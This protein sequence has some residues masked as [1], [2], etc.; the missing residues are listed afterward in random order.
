[1][2]FSNELIKIFPV[3]CFHIQQS[4]L[5]NIFMFVFTASRR[6][7]YIILIEMDS[8]YTG[9]DVYLHNQLLLLKQNDCVLELPKIIL[10]VTCEY[11]KMSTGSLVDTVINKPLR[12]STVAACLQQVLGMEKQKKEL[13]NGPTNLRNLLAGK[14]IL[15]IDDN[16][17]NL[18]VAASALKKYGARV[19]CAESGKDALSLLQL[20]HKFDACFMDVQMPEMDGYA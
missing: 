8:W 3:C 6:Q 19:E 10:L 13:S 17:V 14:N 9:M 2:P 4:P 15:V 5:T 20:P 12:A 18:R 16:K 1:M 11:D 7:P